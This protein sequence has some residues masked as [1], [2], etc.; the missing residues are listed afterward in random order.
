[1]G[2]YLLNYAGIWTLGIDLLPTVAKQNIHLFV[3]R[4][5]YC[6]MKA[7]VDFIIFN[8]IIFNKK[9]RGI[10]KFL[11]KTKFVRLKSEF[12]GRNTF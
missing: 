6:S 12:F 3:Y 4:G 5:C 10:I 8:K 9:F 7:W 11:L 2:A 1:M